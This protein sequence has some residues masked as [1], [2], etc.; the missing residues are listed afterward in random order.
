MGPAKSQ[1]LLPIAGEATAKDA[2]SNCRHISLSIH[3]EITSEDELRVTR[4][5]HSVLCRARSI[6][7]FLDLPA[8]EFVSSHE[9]NQKDAAPT[10]A[11]AARGTEGLTGDTAAEGAAQVEGHC[12]YPISTAASLYRLFPIPG[13]ASVLSA[14][15]LSSGART[16]SPPDVQTKAQSAAQLLS[17]FF[18]FAA[19]NCWNTL[20]VT[21]THPLPT[22]SPRFFDIRG[23]GGV[24]A[25][26][27]L[28]ANAKWAVIQEITRVY[29]C[30][31]ADRWTFDQICDGLDPVTE[32]ALFRTD[33][34]LMM[35]TTTT[36]INTPPL[37]LRRATQPHS[38]ESLY[39]RECPGGTG[40]RTRD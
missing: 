5:L 2:Q 12:T 36:K 15:T 38:G 28:T 11:T 3:R 6:P 8:F 35:G 29:R 39:S 16:S 34:P 32:A 27:E 25:C 40:A 37:C 26:R 20:D 14:P 13:D 1:K 31:L 7:Q 33:A 4:S 19:E 23:I 10:T 9:D 24:N 18:R 17:D 30:A 22:Q 21:K